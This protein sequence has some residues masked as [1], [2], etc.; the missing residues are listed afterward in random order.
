MSIDDKIKLM[1][2][3]IT[4]LSILNFILFAFIFGAI[5]QTIL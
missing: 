5:A 3:I 4:F 2:K 1:S